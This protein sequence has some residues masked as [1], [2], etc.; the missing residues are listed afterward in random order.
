MPR[1]RNSVVIEESLERVFSFITNTANCNKWYPCKLC[2]VTNQALQRGD[3][4]VEEFNLAGRQ[5]TILWTVRKCVPP[6]QWT[7]AGHSDSGGEAT[8]TYNLAP[9]PMGTLLQRTFIY[10]LAALLG[11]KG[12]FFAVQDRLQAEYAEALRK[13]KRVLES[14]VSAP[15]V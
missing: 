12:S 15:A 4:F 6:Y 1:I 5:S 11:Q 2:G 7:L 10:S 8:I 9:N 14:E 13:L 3:R